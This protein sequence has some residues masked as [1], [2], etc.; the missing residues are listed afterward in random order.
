VDEDHAL[1]RREEHDSTHADALDADRTRLRQVEIE[2][3]G[4]SSPQPAIKSPTGRGVRR[5]PEDLHRRTLAE[6]GLWYRI[7]SA[8][9]TRGGIGQRAVSSRP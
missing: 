8:A 2:L 1:H 3:D 5:L 7:P 9:Y 6:S 4:C